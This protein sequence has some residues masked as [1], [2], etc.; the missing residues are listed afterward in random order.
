MPWGVGVIGAGPGV[1]AL[2]LPTLGRAARPVPRRPRDRP[3]QR[4]CR[5]ARRRGSAPRHRRAPPSSSPIPPS[6]WSRSAARPSE[7]AR[8]IR[9]GVAAGVRAILCEKP[10]ATTT[11]EARDGRRRVPARPASCSSWRP[12]TSTTRPG[13]ARSTTSWPCESDVRTISATVALPPNGRYHAAVT[14]LGPRGC[15]RARGARP[16]RSGRR[17]AGRATARARARGAR[18]PG[19]AR[20]GARLRGRRLRRGRRADRLHGRLPCRRR[21]RAADRRHA[22]RRARSG[23]AAHDRHVDG[24]RR[25]GVPAL[26]RARGQRDGARCAPATC[27]RRPTGATTEDGY[28]RE[29]RALAALLDGTATMEYHEVLDDAIFAIDLADAAAAA[30]HAGAPS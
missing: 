3:R 27:A 5:G 17:R 18:P 21:A 9:E 8:Q 14:E 1:A 30:I 26:V 6:R 24:P 11:D 19:R 23:L 13:I 4:P 22:A 15:A 12:T 10:L 20:P 7:H 25:R 28:V 29:W 16:R 2:H